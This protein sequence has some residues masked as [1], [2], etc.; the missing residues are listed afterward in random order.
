MGR[1]CIPL[2]LTLV[3]WTGIY[4]NSRGLRV[5]EALR[6]NGTIELDGVLEEKIW[7]GKGYSEFIQSEPIDGAAATEK[8]VVRVA[9][10][11]KAIYISARLFDSEP[12]KI[13]GM[14][15]RR[16]EFVDSDWFI[17][18][19]DPYYDRRSGYQFAVNPA[20]SMVDWT[21]YNDEYTDSTWDGVWESKT[22]IDNQGWC[23]EIRIPFEQLRFKQK[24]DYVW[25]INF[26]R[27]IKR[28]NEQAG[29]IWVPKNG[30]G[31]VS[32]FALLEG[33]QGIKPGYHIELM[34]YTVGKAAFGTKEE[35]N[36]F[37]TGK[38][39]YSNSGLDLKIGLKSNLTLNLTI[40]PDFGQVEVDP[41]VI[42]LSAAESYYSEKRPFFIE[43]ADI[44]R[45]GIGGTNRK[46][47]A[48][49]GSYYLFYSRR[50]G[51]APQGT[52]D[53]DGDIDYPDWSTILGAAKITGKIGKG[54]NLGFLSALTQRE[55]AQIHLDGQHYQQ[56]VEPFSAYTV[57]RGQKEFNQGRQGLGF[58]ST[59]VVRDLRTQELNDSL[60]KNAFSFGVD[61]WTFLD[62]D[63]IWVVSSWFG[64]TRVS[65]SREAI[66]GLQQS[67]PHYFQRPDA[68]HVKL[69]ENAT[70]MSGWAGRILF[71]KQKGNFIINAAL[72]AVSPG[73]NCMDLG[74]QWSADIINGH[75]MAAYRSFKP[76]KIFRN[77]VLYLFTQRNYDFGGHKT[78]EQR[79]IFISEAQFLNYW[80]AY[81]Q[82]S[83][84]P[85]RWSKDL[86]RGGPLTL[87]PPSTWGEI[88]I[89]SDD[90]KPLVASL[91]YSFST[92]ESGSNEHG[93]SLGLQWKPSSN[94]SISIEPQYSTSFDVAQWVTAKEDELMVDTYGTRYVFGSIDQKTLS[95]IIRLDWIFSP[96]LSLQAYIQPFIAVGAYYDF[97]EL[98]H[99][100][101][102]DFNNFGQGNST[103]IYSPED[104]I[105]TVDPDGLGAAPIFTF[106]N[107][108]FNYKSLRG[109]VV[110]RWEYRPGSTLYL[111]WTQNRADYSNPGD[112]QFGRDLGNL[113][114]APGDNIF[115]LKFTYR[116]NI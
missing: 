55:Y 11:D 57:L 84:N 82:I 50:I 68:T 86:T 114:K 48:N 85:K 15:G 103:I 33:I 49:W 35:G 66:W 19:V 20:G 89:D 73:F 79:L 4:G 99:P 47:S 24:T 61:G 3:F 51:R 17:V 6:V 113:F 9:Y 64:V 92:S 88:G 102:F 12:E 77:W 56:E 108:D 98:A 30:S 87:L 107:P 8:T 94:L 91:F 69:D 16:D 37:A 63:K 36:P 18:S 53:T 105:Y 112:F 39:Y 76:G 52:V 96:K 100:R 40:N 46:I 111:V 38:E 26:R 93:I 25:G 115:M 81:A 28:K 14:L 32:H 109:T 22:S 29:F 21:I 71:N 110:F 10:D 54:W 58:I 62:K 42:N 72:G 90:R 80:E 65:G 45:F 1:M 43:G 34:P 23:V 104:G 41:A 27:F 7:K 101:S 106:E 44:F 74:F 13:I 2:L 97:K 5:V 75:I 116:F 70:S 95:C 83:V 67:Y 31:F 60:N 78:G 59:G